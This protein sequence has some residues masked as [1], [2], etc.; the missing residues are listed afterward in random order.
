MEE[1]TKKGEKPPISLRQ[2][3]GWQQRTKNEKRM[4]FKSSQHRSVDSCCVHVRPGKAGGK[5][6]NGPDVVQNRSSTSVTTKDSYFNLYQLK[7]EEKEK[8]SVQA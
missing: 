7:M 3:V 1:A 8:L 2:F 5:R 4:R 6:E